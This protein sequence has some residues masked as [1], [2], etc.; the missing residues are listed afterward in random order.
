VSEVVSEKDRIRVL[1]R[2]WLDDRELQVVS[3]GSNLHPEFETYTYDYRGTASRRFVCLRGFTVGETGVKS[4]EKENGQSL[5]SSGLRD[6]IW[7][8]GAKGH[9]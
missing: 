6:F 3:S 8:L 5:D 1:V 4:W 7:N 9:G 2:C